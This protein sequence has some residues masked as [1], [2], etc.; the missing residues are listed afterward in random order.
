MKYKTVYD[1][2]KKGYLHQKAG[3]KIW[4]NVVRREEIEL[5]YTL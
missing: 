5:F 3:R 2:I 4:K 1:I